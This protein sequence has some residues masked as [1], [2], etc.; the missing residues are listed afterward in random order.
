MLTGIGVHVE[1]E[2]LF[3]SDSVG[4]VMRIS[5]GDKRLRIAVYPMLIQP[6]SL[7]VDWLNDDIYVVSQN[8]IYRCAVE[9]TD[10]QV[11]LDG[12]DMTPTDIKVDPING[13]LYFTIAAEGHGLYRV[14]MAD[15]DGTDKPKRKLIIRNELLSSFTID[16]QNIQLYFPNDSQN[17]MLATFLDGSDVSNIRPNV[18]RPDFHHVVSMVY[19]QG[20]FYWTNGNVVLQEEYDPRRKSYRH[21]SMPFFENH[22]RGFNMLHPSAQPKPVPHSPP[23]RVEVVFS[24]RKAFITWGKPPLMNYQGRGAWN[25]WGYEVMV[26]DPQGKN[27]SNLTYD[28]ELVIQGL[29]PGVKYHVNIRATSP[30]GDG[31]WSEAFIGTTLK[32]YD[33]APAVI[34]GVNSV[35]INTSMDGQ[36]HQL[37]GNFSSWGV[38]DVT[39][40]KSHLF[41]TG[42][43]VTKGHIFTESPFSVD[44]YYI[45][46]A[47][48][49]AFDWLGKKLYWSNVKQ[50]VIRR[51]DMGGRN[52]EIVYP[53]SA[54][55]LVIDSLQGRLYWVT[56]HSVETAHL[57]GDDPL[58]YFAVPHFAG[59]QIHSLALDHEKHNIYWL[60]QSFESQDLYMSPTVEHAVVD[61]PATVKRVGRLNSVNRQP[62]LQIFSGRLIWVNKM[63]DLMVSD[64][65][66][67]YS[68]VMR[69]V[70]GNVSSVVVIHPSLQPYPAGLDESSL[71]IIPSAISEAA[72][73]VTGD[74]S[75]FNVTWLASKE[76]NYGPVMYKL[77]L[78]APNQQYELIKK[79]TWHELV[80]IP[81][82]SLFTIS[83][84]AFT[85]WG[86]APWVT[87]TLRSPMSVPS[88]PL[89]PRVYI[90]SRKDAMTSQLST[91]ADFRW[92]TPHKIHGIIDHHIVFYRHANKT[93]P[94]TSVRVEASSRHFI[95]DNLASNC[96]YYFQVQAC[97]MIG[98]GP[99]SKIKAAV[100]DAENP[101]PKLLI[102][103][104]SGLRLV[105]VE[106]GHNK[107]VTMATG[108]PLAITYLAQDM[109][110][111]WIDET[112]S[113]VEGVGD[114]DRRVTH[115]R[116]ILLLNGT[117]KD[118]T[119]DWIS[120]SLYISLQYTE[121]SAIVSYDIERQELTR[122]I[123][124][125]YPI[126][127][128]LADPF[129]S[130]LFWTE[131]QDSRS[132]YLMK[133]RMDGEEIAA[134]F[135]PDNLTTRRR[136]RQAAD[137]AACNC[138]TQ[139]QVAPVVAIDHSMKGTTKLYFI[140][141]NGIALVATDTDACHCNVELPTTPLDRKGLPPDS[142]TA[143]HL[144][145]YWSKSDSGVHSLDKASGHH[146]V[147]SQHTG[148]TSI[149][150]YGQHLQPLPGAECLDPSIQ[151]KSLELIDIANTSLTFRLSI[152]VRPAMCQAISMPAIKYTIY[153]T[154][155]LAD[156][157][158]QA[159]C[160][161]TSLNCSK[162]ETYRDVITVD[163]LKPYTHYLFQVAV[164]NYYTE[165]LSEEMGPAMIYQTKVGIPSPVENVTASAVLPG[166]IKVEFDVP[167]IA[168]GPQDSIYYVVKWM[169]ATSENGVLEGQTA[170]EQNHNKRHRVGR[171]VPN[172]KPETTY[173][174]KVLAY[175]ESQQYY[176]ESKPV[177]VTTFAF[178][179]LINCTGVTETTIN[180]T[181]MSPKDDSIHS[182]NFFIKKYVP[183]E[184]MAE[185]DW[186]PL[187]LTRTENNTQY[188]ET[189][190]D[191]EPGTR[192][193]F[194][195]TVVYRSSVVL[196]WPTD[197]IFIFETQ[198]GPMRAVG[199]D[200]TLVVAVTLAVIA[201]IFM[202]GLAICFLVK[203][204][205]LDK[206]R[207]PSH[208]VNGARGPDT[209]LAILRELP[210]TT[211]QQNNT[212][213]AISI[214][215][216]DE[217]I[218]A[219][220]HFSR[221]QLNLTK[222]LGS[223]AF[224][225]VFEGV[226]KDILGS[227]SGDTKVAV[228]TLRKSASDQEKEEFLKE[229]LLMSN[230]KHEHILSLLGVCLDN[231]PQFIILELMEGGD[232]LSFLRN[233]RPS[234]C[235]P[236]L[237]N[238][239]DL[240]KICLHVARGCGYLEN[241]HF[242]H[243]DLAARNCLVSSKDPSLMSVKIGDFGLA[244]DIYKNDYYRK[245]G[246]GLLPVRWMSPESLVDGVFT[247]QSDIWAFGV[248]V[249]EVITL[250]QQ[251]YPARTNIEVL[252]YV[253]AGGRLDRPENC[254]DDLYDLV[255][256]CWSCPPEDRPC[257]A[258]IHNQ[259]EE[260]YEKSLDEHSEFS[261]LWSK[262]VTNEAGS[263][264]QSPTNPDCLRQWSSLAGAE[265][266]TPSP[267]KELNNN[268]R[269]SKLPSSS[270]QS[271]CD[272]AA[273]SG[274]L[275]PKSQELHKYLELISDPSDTPVISVPSGGARPKNGSYR[276]PDS[277]SPPRYPKTN[278]AQ[279]SAPVVS[280]QGSALP[281]SACKTA[282]SVKQSSKP[283]IHYAKLASF[284]GDEVSSDSDF[285]GRSSDSLENLPLAPTLADNQGRFK[286]PGSFSQ[287]HPMTPPIAQYMIPVST[288][289]SP[290]SINPSAAS[291]TP[292]GPSVRKDY[293]N[294]DRGDNSIPPSSTQTSANPE[295]MWGSGV[296]DTMG[297]MC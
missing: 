101:V 142:L 266:Y 102:A 217:D 194:R 187:R 87:R 248:L 83:I 82:F 164:S 204:R 259:L 171:V 32:H 269:G 36:R 160:D 116:K 93:G 262:H 81:P 76:V 19:H 271:P 291:S 4:K 294:M 65:R 115:E 151:N 10:C 149:Q 104:R 62:P 178:P 185:G 91:A 200:N 28:L 23:S 97:T 74:W 92:S 63:N 35:I 38:G 162:L 235:N 51:C 155:L 265:N 86:Y 225:E 251:P 290:E 241:M 152:A 138:S 21:N 232:L 30:E 297:T 238:L 43:G 270:P 96:T 114:K 20:L 15:L 239:S 292:P 234:V 29:S 284:D 278:Y 163:K 118:I 210:H 196:A 255:T 7:T 16:Y 223:G 247:T 119:V 211:V 2:L 182:H 174:I 212:L 213:Y 258:T 132:G 267:D 122:V 236:P 13:F 103:S 288:P 143:D 202:L 99:R 18:I 128:V 58:E 44:Y 17:T 252:H 39:W 50:I 156:S 256:Q 79:N 60:V 273:F 203:C 221:D 130:Q 34:M 94:W 31:P 59:R 280:G 126:G 42:T 193:V 75:S 226:A 253:R 209:E 71:V 131:S 215:P 293:V 52:S 295:M 139:P 172:L 47:S 33:M 180:I 233:S 218:E 179:G 133:G 274:Y 37:V 124:R 98:C 88:R 261:A 150:A 148:V 40:Y 146:S 242:V 107:S 41:W 78:E 282:P 70:S 264:R 165:Y 161:Q 27:L 3:V 289:N 69:H 231:D 205:R 123:S 186:Q 125:P 157:L 283:G 219:L 8:K 129:S 95:L 153:Y 191:L 199:E 85:Y 254:P 249:W 275:Q 144:K 296:L 61:L 192:Y 277:H 89:T 227:E 281:L 127:S 68:A 105:E 109:K 170:G 237:L 121:E 208:F 190:T 53:T 64:L 181:W 279:I 158:Q 175:E 6:E 147:I 201:V 77:S 73:Q 216:T 12:L 166:K 222:F 26:S 268:H 276:S 250:G 214:I 184:G 54:K 111:F 183:D 140:K 159:K 49:L 285:E 56:T 113:L 66:G 272:T 206:K 106:E 46:D 244:R 207:K 188:N 257:F 120:R 228:K 80:G 154:E 224:G 198:Y 117:G 189:F 22:F 55:Q 5:L 48:C 287:V 169:T 72:V 260:F 173:R 263:V 220:P 240:V 176:S 9:K 195:V 136:R 110:F 135:S 25:T 24:D 168:N 57:N 1:K 145:I 246:E 245:E 90:T 197:P 177:K 84:Q 11:A 100:T 230:F 141:T 286:R 108:S 229:A 112:N 45:V 14:D 167:L 137:S 134:M 243:R 67:N